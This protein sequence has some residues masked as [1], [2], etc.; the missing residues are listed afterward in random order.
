MSLFSLKRNCDEIHSQI[1][2]FNWSFNVAQTS[3]NKKVLAM[4][5]T[6]LTPEAGFNGLEIKRYLL[7]WRSE[8]NHGMKQSGL[9]DLVE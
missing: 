3:C 4:V 2:A 7:W 9:W 8:I 6:T 1:V 5:A